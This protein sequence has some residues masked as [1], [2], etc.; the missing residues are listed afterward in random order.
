[1]GMDPCLPDIEGG[2]GL[3]YK[4]KHEGVVW[5]KELIRVS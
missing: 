4:G 5:V 2:S 3:E 1:M